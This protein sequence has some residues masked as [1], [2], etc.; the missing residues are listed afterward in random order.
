VVGPAQC[1]SFG[2]DVLLSHVGALVVH[3]IQCRLVV[4]STE[5]CKHFGESGN[6]QGVG[7]GLHWLHGNCFNRL[8]V[9]VPYMEPL[10]F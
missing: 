5:Y 10:Y 7:A 3:H 2:L 9:T 4:T 8:G 1:S 6:E